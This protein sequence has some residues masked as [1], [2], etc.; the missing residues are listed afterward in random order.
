[1]LDAF[2]DFEF[3]LADGDEVLAEGHSVPIRWDGT[4]EG[5]PAGIDGAFESAFSDEEPNTL[6]AMAIEILPAHQSRRLSVPMLEEMKALAARAGFDALLAPLRPSWKD[7]Y[8]LTP[9]ERYVA[10]TRDDG[11]PFDPWLRVHVRL[12]GEMLKPEPES[13]RITGTVAEWESWTGMAF[14]ETGTYVFPQGLAPVEIDREADAGRYWEPNVW[15][16]HRV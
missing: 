3:V 4:V 10:W 11:L 9:I 13:L 14:P 1:M 12:G 6:C 16:L 8:P 5:L 15:V 2:P 7:R